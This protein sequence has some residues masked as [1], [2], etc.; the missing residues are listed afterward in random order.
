MQNQ[1]VPGTKSGGEKKDSLAGFRWLEATGETR[2][3][4]LEGHQISSL[5]ADIRNQPLTDVEFEVARPTAN[6][7]RTTRRAYDRN[8]NGER[9]LMEVL[10]EDVRSSGPDAFNATRTRSE[11]DVNGNMQIVMKQAQETAPAGPGSYRTRTTTMVQGVS[12][13]LSPSGEIIQLEKKKADGAVEIERTQQVP[14]ANGGWTPGDRRTSTTRVENGRSL[15]E[16]NIY[17]QDANG[18]LALTQKEVSREWTDAQGRVVQ[19]KEISLPNPSGRFE[20]NARVAIVRETYADGSQ[21]TTQT[22]FQKSAVDPSGGM[23]TVEVIVQTD[24]PAGPNA[25]ERLTVIQ[26]PDANGKL[27]TVGYTKAVVRK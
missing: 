3:V 2:G 11:R 6:S 21:Q 22:R 16:D 5:V 24:S 25:N 17:W 12:G 23:K 4:V 26:F 1:A 9:V 8:A 27:E 19:E 10:V 13:A 20:L 7:V 14:S 18:K 15:T